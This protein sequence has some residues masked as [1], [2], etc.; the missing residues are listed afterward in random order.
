MR[1]IFVKASLLA[2]QDVPRREQARFH[3]F[4]PRR[5]SLWNTILDEWK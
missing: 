3:N 4:N 1:A 2:A 5:I